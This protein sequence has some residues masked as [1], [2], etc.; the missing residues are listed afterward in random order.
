MEMEPSGFRSRILVVL[1]DFT[2][3]MRKQ[4]IRPPQP[5]LL[6]VRMESSCLGA[7]GPKTNSLRYLAGPFRPFYCGES[8]LEL[9]AWLHGRRGGRRW[10][11]RVW[12]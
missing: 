8:A 9:T 1:C 7:K 3:A 5:W 10:C 6:L 4:R 11:N 12:R 2:G